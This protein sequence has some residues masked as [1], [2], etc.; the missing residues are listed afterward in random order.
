MRPPVTAF[1]L[2]PLPS[3]N[4]LCR[5]AKGDTSG[6]IVQAPEGPNLFTTRIGHVPFEE[7]VHVEITYVGELKQNLDSMYFSIPAW[8]APH[9]GLNSLAKHPSTAESATSS[10]DHITGG[11]KITVDMILPE[12]Q[13][14]KRVE[15]PWHMIA[16]S[17]GTDSAASQEGPTMIWASAT[18]SNITT[19]L[20]KDFL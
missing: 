5:V 11:I 17:A 14:I 13:V 2:P 4:E 9:Y 10:I 6:I 15:S 8:I 16:V 7:R 18:L 12:G 19:G 20:E 3:S 1:R